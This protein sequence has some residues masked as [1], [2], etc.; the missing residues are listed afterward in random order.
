MNSILVYGEKKIDLRWL[1]GKNKKLGNKYL[2][3]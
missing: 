3:W 2:T 1:I